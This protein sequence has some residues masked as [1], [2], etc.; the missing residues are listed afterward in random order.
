MSS[1]FS[2]DS[3][4]PAAAPGA[5]GE[6][7]APAWVGA[8]LVDPHSSLDKAGK[9]RRMFSSIACSYDL[10]NRLHSLWL[11]QHWRRVAGRMAGGR[12]G[13]AVLDVAC[14]TGDLTHLFAKTRAA[15]VVGLD[16]T[17]AMLDVARRKLDTKRFQVKA[18]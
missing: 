6:E 8:E 10:N 16:F 18:K 11:D 9:V 17:A 12:P 4:S 5:G 1:G 14:G 7:G 3:K 2:S 15:S 13:D